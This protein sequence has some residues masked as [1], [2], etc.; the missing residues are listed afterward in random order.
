[1]IITFS[2]FLTTPTF[3]E[4]IAIAGASGF[5]GR[6]FIDQFKH[7]YKFIAI[8]RR[9]VIEATD[10]H[11]EWRQADLY[12]LTSTQNALAGADY[13]IYLVH[14]M[15]PSTRLN[16]SSFEDTDLILADNF[17]R[18]AEKHQLKQLIFIGGIL[19]DKSEELSPHLRSRYEVE[20][21]LGARKTPFTALRAG[22]IVG[23]GGSSFTIIEKLV[24]RLPMM[25][26]PNWTLSK[27]H[28]IALRDVLTILDLCI[29]NED[30]YNEAIEV[31]GPDVLSYKEMLVTTAQ[32]MGKKRLIFPLPIFPI[33]LSKAWVGFFSDSSLTFVAPL[34]ESLKHELIATPHPLLEKA[35]IDYLSFED[36]V[37]D[38]LE[39]KDLIPELPKREKTGPVKHRNTVRSV[40]RL[41]N[42]VGKDATW[43]AKRYTQ[44]LP[45][46]LKSFIQAKVDED[47]NVS[48]HLLGTK[49]P[50]LQLCF[51]KE[52]SGADRQLF[53]ISGG[54]L[55]KKDG[56]G[57]LEFRN[58]LNQKYVMAAIHE[59]VP[60][61]PWYIYVNTQAII[62]LWVMNSFNAYLKRHPKS[63]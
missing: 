42:P 29:G 32:L 56:R 39:N 9:K 37:K 1:M 3:M 18:A 47:E 60:T 51:V 55:A 13:A 53:T 8:S 7:K 14:S 17:A 27:T 58:V 57:W 54:L 19:P 45:D 48:F 6:W 61:L 34:V 21:T 35:N 12:S 2:I 31:G 62:H 23:P 44:W 16:Q 20:L 10:P 40:Q 49:L 28:P 15:M 4:T 46:F 25:G 36:A 22:I 59:F 41:V 11:V 33:G 52:R 24:G 38:A 43:V 30:A 26:C 50:L 5:I 63:D